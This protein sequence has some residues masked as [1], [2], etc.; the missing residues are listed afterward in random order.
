MKILLISLSAFLMMGCTKSPS[1]HKLDDAI[2]TGNNITGNIHEQ[3]YFNC[4]NSSGSKGY[5]SKRH[6][7]RK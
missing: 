6:N 4:I 2:D 1:C 3:G 7:Y 5:C